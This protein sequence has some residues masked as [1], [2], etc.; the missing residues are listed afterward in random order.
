MPPAPPGQQWLHNIEGMLPQEAHY[1]LLSLRM[2]NLTERTNRMAH[3][4][5]LSRLGPQCERN[6]LDYSIRLLEMNGIIA[7]LSSPG[8]PHY[9]IAVPIEA[10][11][12]YLYKHDPHLRP[13]SASDWF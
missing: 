8:G 11:D 10:V 6:R 9:K 7:Q 5:L 3:S 4:V 2:W 1:T 12:K 13:A